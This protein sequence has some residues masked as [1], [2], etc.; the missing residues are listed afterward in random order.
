M[1]AGPNG[2]L[3]AVTVAVLLFAANTAF[4][5][6]MFHSDEPYARLNTMYL[7]AADPVLFLVTVGVYAALTS[8]SMFD[9]FIVNTDG[10]LIVYFTLVPSKVIDIMHLLS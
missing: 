10:V 6:A 3:Y 1:R 7:V 5:Q 8:L 4:Q 9:S 2:V